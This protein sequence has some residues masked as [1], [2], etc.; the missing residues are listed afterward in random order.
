MCELENYLPILQGEAAI[1]L[2]QLQ[3]ALG[4]SYPQAKAALKQLQEAAWAGTKV[5]GIFYELNGKTLSPKDLTQEECQ[6]LADQLSS[7]QMHALGLLNGQPNGVTGPRL[8]RYRDEFDVLYDLGLAHVFGA[9]YFCSVTQ[10]SVQR[11]KALQ[12]PETDDVLEAYIGNPIL[13]NAVALDVDPEPLLEL[14]FVPKRCKGYVRNGLLNQRL[15]GDAPR[16]VRYVGKASKKV[17]SYE[18]VEAMM[19]QLDLHGKEDYEEAAKACLAVIEKSLL[20]S[21]EFKEA[22]RVAT[23]EICEGLTL[24]NLREIRNI[25]LS[26]T[27]EEDTEEDDD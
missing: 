27:S 13:V 15:C 12:L 16:P 10:G 1:S 2:P 22:A 8:E 5:D 11:I 19:T 3:K 4:C 24:S 21:E 17:L 23:T 7:R 20:C 26:N 25:I 9:G 18:L 6:L 14:A